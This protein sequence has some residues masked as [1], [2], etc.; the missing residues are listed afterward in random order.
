MYN[1]WIRQSLC[2]EFIFIEIKKLFSKSG[3]NGITATLLALIEKTKQ[4]RKLLKIAAVI[5]IS[6]SSGSII[7]L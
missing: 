6:Q 1:R 3:V 7:F 4:K 2:K 5:T